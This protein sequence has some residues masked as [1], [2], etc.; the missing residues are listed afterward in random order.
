MHLAL[1]PL[2]MPPGRRSAWAAAVL[3]ISVPAG[4]D[5]WRVETGI[6][7]GAARTACFAACALVAPEALDPELLEILLQPW[8]NVVGLPVVAPLR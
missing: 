7:F 4:D 6:G 1:S 8:R 2:A 3:E 5:C